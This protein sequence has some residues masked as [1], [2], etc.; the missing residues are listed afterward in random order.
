MMPVISKELKDWII[1]S[2]DGWELKPGAPKEIVKEFEWL[3]SPY[4]E[5]IQKYE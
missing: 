2:F 1:V 4:D 5:K 3:T